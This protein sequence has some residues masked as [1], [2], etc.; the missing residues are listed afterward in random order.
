[1]Q[2]NPEGM[3]SFGFYECEQVNSVIRWIQRHSS[4]KIYLWGRSMG[5]VTAL[6]YQQKYGRSNALILDSP[7]HS[8]REIFVS[9]FSSLT[10][11]PRF[12]GESTVFLINF[13]FKKLLHFDIDEMDLLPSL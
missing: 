2:I 3:I 4:E 12:L 13:F 6:L 10:R 11:L 9:Q 7:F 8:L 1:M 5:A